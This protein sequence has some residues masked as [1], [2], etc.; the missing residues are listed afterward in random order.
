MAA[1]CNCPTGHTANKIGHH[2]GCPRYQ[3][4]QKTGYETSLSTPFGA[5]PKHSDG[6]THDFSWATHVTRETK[7]RRSQ[8]YGVCKCGMRTLPE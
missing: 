8:S 3:E 6:G 1:K 4:D 7:D 2:Q 5:W